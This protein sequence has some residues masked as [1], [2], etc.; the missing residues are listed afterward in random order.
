M[1]STITVVLEVREVAAFAA[2][3]LSLILDAFVIG[4]MHQKKKEQRHV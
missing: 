1:D 4:T 3:F 2:A